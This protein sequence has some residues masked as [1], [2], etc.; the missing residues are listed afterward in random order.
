MIQPC[1][2]SPSTLNGCCRYLTGHGYQART[3]G[4]PPSANIK[5]T[6]A[7]KASAL[8]CASAFFP[9]RAL[10][11]PDDAWRKAMP[12]LTVAPMLAVVGVIVELFLL[13]ADIWSMRLMGTNG[14]ACLALIAL[15]GIGPLVIFLALLRHGAPSSPALA[16][17]VCGVFAGAIAATVFLAH[18]PDDSPLF[19]AT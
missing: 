9:A 17:A 11:Y 18:C 19:V 14:L 12:Y 10:S 15:I 3:R 5:V 16:G 2:A 1:E 8:A 7:F 6:L 4:L 13:P